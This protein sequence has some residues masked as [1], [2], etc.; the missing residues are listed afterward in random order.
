MFSFFKNSKKE[1]LEEKEKIFDI[2]SV[3]LTEYEI[4]FRNTLL[5]YYHE[6][7]I[8]V[9]KIDSTTVFDCSVVCFFLYEDTKELNIAFPIPVRNDYTA[10]ITLEFSKLDYIMKIDIVDSFVINNGKMY[11]G[12]EAQEIYDKI[13]YETI[14]DDIYKKNL[15]DNLLD[16]YDENNSLPN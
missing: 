2:N 14:Y 12:T 8:Y 16:D 3:E 9:E 15:F 7:N 10:R 5:I 4:E 11:S 1:I 13:I 6:D